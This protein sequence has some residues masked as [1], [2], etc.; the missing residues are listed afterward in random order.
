MIVEMIARDVGEACRR[1]A[2]TVKSILVEAVRRS[3]DREMADPVAGQRVE[4][5]MQR[6]RVGCR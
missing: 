3:F 1:D 2:Q 6:D 5:A 4:R